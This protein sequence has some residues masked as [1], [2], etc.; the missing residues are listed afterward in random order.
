MLLMLLFNMLAETTRVLGLLV[1]LG[2]L[3]SLVMLGVLWLFLFDKIVR[4]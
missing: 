1:L 3:G 2:V 4:V